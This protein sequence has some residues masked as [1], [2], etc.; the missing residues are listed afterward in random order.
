MVVLVLKLDG[1]SLDTATEFLTFRS[2][3]S[4]S[5]PSGTPKLLYSGT[6]TR[7]AATALPTRY[8]PEP[9]HSAWKPNPT[10]SPPRSIGLPA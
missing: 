7:L 5:P 3:G 2:S 4:G 1:L 9:M 6:T 10:M 8:A